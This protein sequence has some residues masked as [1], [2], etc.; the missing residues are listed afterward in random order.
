MTFNLLRDRKVTTWERDSYFIE[1]E[2][3]EEALDKLLIMVALDEQ[4]EESRGFV[5]TETISEVSQDLTLEE[6]NNEAT[7]E[8]MDN[9]TGETLYT[10]ADT[11]KIK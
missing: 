10:N 5:D 11:V 6:N 9:A 1:A 3:R 4:Y 2:T 8:I 7:I